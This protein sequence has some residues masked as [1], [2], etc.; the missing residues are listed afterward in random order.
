MW[1]LSRSQ[2]FKIYL[3]LVFEGSTSFRSVLVP[4]VVAVAL[5]TLASLTGRLPIAMLFINRFTEQSVHQELDYQ[6]LTVGLAFSASF[7]ATLLVHRVSSK[8]MLLGSCSLMGASTVFMALLSYFQ[9]DTAKGAWIMDSG[10]IVFIIAYEFGFGPL[11]WTV[12]T[13]LLPCRLPVELG[14]TASAGFFNAF[15]LLFAMTIWHLVS[16][17]GISGIFI[18]H[19]VV[20]VLS[21]GFV[22]LSL[23]SP[24]VTQNASLSSIERYYHRLFLNEE[25][26]LN[27][28]SL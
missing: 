23:P 6:T 1:K 7:C 21:Y 12:A 14:L 5:M 16:T 28:S 11:S 15:N 27:E 9:Q 3:L 13:E 8:F 19:S 10:A 4:A 20:S 18:I 22:L 24:D 26:V 17:I 25:D 2:I